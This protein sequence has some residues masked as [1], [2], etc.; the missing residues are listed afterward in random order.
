MCLIECL[1]LCCLH[2]G[3]ILDERVKQTKYGHLSYEKLYKLLE[4]YKDVGMMAKLP[5]DLPKLKRKEVPCFSFG[6]FSV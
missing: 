4:R 1:T 5:Q 2:C 6:P 3:Q